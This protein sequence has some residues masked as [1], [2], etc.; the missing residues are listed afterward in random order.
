MN[1]HLT[2]LCTVYDTTGIIFGKCSEEV[3]NSL[4]NEMQVRGSVSL[5]AFEDRNKLKRLPRF[6]KVSN[7]LDIQSC[8]MIR[9]LPKNLSVGRTLYCHNCT[10][11]NEVPKN[12][13][14]GGTLQLERCSSLLELPEGMKIGRQLDL[15]RSGIREIP[16]DIII[17]I[18]L[19]IGSCFDINEDGIPE[20]AQIGGK[21]IYN[22]LSTI[23]PSR[24]SETVREKLTKTN[25]PDWNDI[26]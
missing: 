19:L 23:E 10:L 26:I 20:S 9:S 13:K 4:P 14:V 22:D 21:I 25:N 1:A 2:Y 11:L 3:V 24:L 5:S 7:D 16:N 6:L 15:R 12:L 18:N 8:Y 17:G